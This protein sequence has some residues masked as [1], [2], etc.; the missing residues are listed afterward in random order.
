MTTTVPLYPLRFEPILKR[1]IWGGRRLGIL[2]NKPLGEHPDYAESWEISDH[3]DDVSRVAEGPL[4]GTSLRDLVRERPIELLGE[5]LPGRTQFPLLVKFLD[6]HQ[7]LSVQ[8]HPDD[9]RAR[10]LAGDNGKTEA[11]VVVHAEPGSLIYAGLKP[12][13][14]RQAFAAAIETGAVEPLLHRFKPRPGDCILIPAGTVHAIGAGVVLAEIQQMSDA[15]FRVFDWGRLGPDG[16]PRKLHLAEALESTD[17]DTGPVNP[18]VADLES[19]P[20]GTRERL[21]RCKH[22]ALERL[23]LVGRA[24]VGHTERFTI[25]IGLG[26]EAE[27]HH[28]GKSYPLRLGHSLLLP[29]AI[30]RCEVVPI[31]GEAVVLTCVVP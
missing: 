5:A 3:R 2:L 11:W 23:T 24:H 17:F 10:R 31:E 30:G 26:D 15:T 25:L 22:F 14:S 28:E 16:R 9:E 4:R 20:G 8:V 7:V 21:A 29:A 6:A 27:V 1:L 12:G 19:I 13:V 18:L